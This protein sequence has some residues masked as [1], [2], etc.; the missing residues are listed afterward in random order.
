MDKQRFMETCRRKETTETLEAYQQKTEAN[1]E[2]WIGARWTTWES[3]QKTWF[4]EAER[5]SSNVSV[6]IK[7]VY[8]MTIMRGN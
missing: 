5:A 3:G 8:E 6:H 2:S 4:T 7:T 1:I